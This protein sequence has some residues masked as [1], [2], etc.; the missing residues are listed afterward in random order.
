[1]FA[2]LEGLGLV[3]APT[4]ITAEAFAA[5]RGLDPA[6]LRQGLG[7]EEIGACPPDTSVADL[8]V[9]AAKRALTDW[10]GDPSRIALLVVGSETALDMSRPRRPG[11]RR[12][13]G[14][15]A[16][17]AAT[18]SSTRVTEV[19]WPSGKPP[20]GWPRAAPPRVPWP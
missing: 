9:A 16:P 20:S 6:K 14:C 11:S 13:W 2:G 3:L 5:L 7:V 10:G 15:R 1:M 8:A 4:A 19:R 18:K 12:G 17:F